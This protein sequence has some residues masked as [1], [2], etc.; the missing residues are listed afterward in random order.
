MHHR[1]GRSAKPNEEERLLAEVYYRS[2][3]VAEKDAHRLRQKNAMV[4]QLAIEQSE[5]EAN[6]AVAEAAR[7]AKLKRQ[8]DK[9]VRR[10]KG[11]VV[12]SSSD[13]DSDDGST[14][15]DDQDPP[16]PR[17]PTAMPATER[18]RPNDEEAPSY[19]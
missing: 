7:V 5:W 3:T 11:L 8:Q 16:P 15:D 12:L 9:S 6:K 1:R 13:S 19:F 18:E 4:L 17:T 10:L 2:L 14:S